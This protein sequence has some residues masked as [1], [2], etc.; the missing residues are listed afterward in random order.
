MGW[1]S[2]VLVKR[3]ADDSLKPHMSDPERDALARNFERAQ[4]LLE[5]GCGGSTALAAASGVARIVSVDSDRAWLDKVAQAPELEGVDFVPVHVD[6]GRTGYWGVPENDRRASGW[7]EYYKSPW[8]H[9][10]RAPDSVF[11]DGRFRVACTLFAILECDSRSQYIIHDFWD[12]P[13]YHCVLDFL[14]C[15]E[16]VDTLG[17]FHA[18]KEIEWRR[19]ARALIDHALDYR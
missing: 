19:L 2:S 11:I 16:R 3:D 14:D 4:L 9:V 1:L 15:I 17:V 8:S 6:V 18:K 10:P 12:R 7:P 13:H 5:F